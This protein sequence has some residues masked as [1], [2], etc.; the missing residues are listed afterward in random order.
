[1]GMADLLWRWRYSKVTSRTWWKKLNIKYI[2]LS[3]EDDVNNR[4]TMNNDAK[5]FNT[6][7]SAKERNM[8]RR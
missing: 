5:V 6:G 3:T 2:I 7:V 1:M 8:N 4:I